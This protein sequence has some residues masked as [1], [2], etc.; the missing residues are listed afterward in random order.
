MRSVLLGNIRIDQK[1][2]GNERAPKP[3]KMLAVAQ[4]VCVGQKVSVYC[5]LLRLAA[6]VVLCPLVTWAQK[7]FLRVSLI[8]RGWSNESIFVA[9]NMNLECILQA[10]DR[11][12]KIESDLSSTWSCKQSSNRLQHPDACLHF[13]NSYGARPLVTPWRP[14]TCAL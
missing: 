11:F 9:V 4:E 12:I 3:V 5:M 6:N 10:R 13:K 14:F 1:R 7:H 8:G 2:T